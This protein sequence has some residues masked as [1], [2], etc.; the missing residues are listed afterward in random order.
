[1]NIKKFL[2]SGITAAVVL[3][4]FSMNVAAKTLEPENKTPRLNLNRNSGSTM[5]V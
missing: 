3:G 2:V 4:T 1:M 5:R